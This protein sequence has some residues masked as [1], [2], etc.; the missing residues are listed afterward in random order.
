MFCF[1]AEE[2][3]RDY[4]EVK[5]LKSELRYVRPEKAESL[6]GNVARIA[7]IAAWNK[8]QV[9]RKLAIGVLGELMQ[10]PR[11]EI[12]GLAKQKYAPFSAKFNEDF[13]ELKGCF[14]R[15][16]KNPGLS[17]EEKRKNLDRLEKFT[18]ETDFDYP[19]QMGKE[20][21]KRIVGA[22]V[23]EATRGYAQKALER[24]EEFETRRKRE[25]E[26]FERENWTIR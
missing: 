12:N 3:L 7:E 6:A 14:Y 11:P 10:H 13:A 5:R 8:S 20:Y 9:I 1:L 24:V 23:D 15:V 16:M 17:F 2:V 21:I 25:G 19:H 22:P 18:L 26:L 4:E